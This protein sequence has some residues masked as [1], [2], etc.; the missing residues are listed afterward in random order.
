MP[1]DP[2]AALADAALQY[3]Y[4]PTIAGHFGAEP[5]EYLIQMV[6]RFDQDAL[7]AGTGVIGTLNVT[8]GDFDADGR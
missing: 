4:S 2:I 8:A 3:R 7:T 5:V 1:P 6:R